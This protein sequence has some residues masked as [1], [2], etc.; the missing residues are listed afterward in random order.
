MNA[1]QNVLVPSSVTDAGVKPATTIAFTEGPAVDAGG[2]V[3]FS[4]IMNCGRASRRVH[5]DSG[6]KA[7]R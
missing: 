1:Y 7:S 6:G 4:D 5:H 2:N 3:Y